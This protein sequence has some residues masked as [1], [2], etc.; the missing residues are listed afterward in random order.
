M[1]HIFIKVYRVLEQTIPE[2]VIGKVAV[3]VSE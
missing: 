1:E 2:E 3:A